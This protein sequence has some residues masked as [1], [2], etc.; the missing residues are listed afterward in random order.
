MQQIKAWVQLITEIPRRKGWWY[1]LFW[2]NLLGSFFGFWWYRAQ[3][4]S[5]PVKF[6]LV[7]PDSPGSTLLF[8]FF[9]LLLLTHRTQTVGETPV[10]VTGWSGV[11]A[12]VAFVSNMKYGLWTAMVL[13]TY[14]AQSG[15]FT[16][17]TVHLSLSHFGMWVQAMLFS[18]F[19]RPG[20]AAAGAA[21]G[22]MLFQDYVD[23]KL[24]DT[25]P[26]LPVDSLEPTA[27]M[28][29][30]VLS[31][32]WGLYLIWLAWKHRADGLRPSR[33]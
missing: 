4:A 6:W 27:R 21:L 9:I 11:L 8:S 31:L 33:A 13:P 28:I 17:E 20:L 26:T 3:L 25:H 29:A 1:L 2:I 30:V 32:T 24:L 22:W 15:I 14:A 18:Y 12:A 19:Y 23:Y 7:V 10:S 5:T 16:F